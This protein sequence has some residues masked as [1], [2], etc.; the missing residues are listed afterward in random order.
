MDGTDFEGPSNAG[1]ALGTSATRSVALATVATFVGY[2]VT[3]LQQVLFARALGVDAQTDALAA[4]LAWGVGT[5]GP[6]GAALASV[7][8]PA[9][10]QARA[11]GDE[12]RARASIQ[13]S[14]GIGL[15]AALLLAIITFLAADSLSAALAP[16]L[17]GGDR[18]RLAGLLRLTAP[19]EFLW[20]LVWLTV[21]R[22]NARKRYVLAAAS[23]AIPP[24]PVILTFVLSPNA[25]VE[26]VALAY[27]VGA[28]L[29]VALVAASVGPL[30]DLR[31]SLRTA[32]AR[33]L[34][35]RLIPAGL[36]FGLMSI[37]GLVLR[38]VASLQGPGAVATADYASR[39]V[40]AGEQ[41]LLSG[42][43][44]VVFTRW[45]H[46]AGAMGSATVAVAEAGGAWS[47]QG[48]VL[49]MLGPVI[50]V[51]F[52][53][54]IVAPPLVS[55]LFQGG[56]FDAEDAGAVA[57]FLG[58]M[59]AGVA[60]HMLVLLA[61][62]ALLAAGRFIILSVVGAVAVV[63]M[64]G[65]GLIAGASM[66]LDGVALAYAVGW[67]AAA[68]VSLVA[69]RVSAPRFAS[70]LGR[71]ILMGAGAAAITILAAQLLPDVAALRLVVVSVAFVLVAAIL[72][73]LLGVTAVR[74]I[75]GRLSGGRR[76]VGVSTGAGRPG[77]QP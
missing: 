66:G 50:G 52:L 33:R 23:F 70:E 6:V 67:F 15:T 68:V 73:R 17:V 24:V 1:R 72:G 38:G 63:T 69:L 13:A 64:W 28:A 2:A 53:L 45:S 18:E 30:G 49:R 37:A 55:I 77:A 10:V 27:I 34:I 51:A 40:V 65:V 60:A 43:L 22:A 25:T 21:A 41:I 14:A 16:G 58:W 39:L 3:L 44:A 36:A 62:R 31:P 20:I 54:P 35:R 19:L 57:R 4:A 32:T 8:L 74:E 76:N 71:A 26:E 46:E 29:Q 12:Q 59:S 75:L 42:L 47:V 9:Y 11:S 56:R 7:A 5:S 61:V 48:A